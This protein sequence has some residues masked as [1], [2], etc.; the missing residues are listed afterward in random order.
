MV[1]DWRGDVV[2]GGKKWKGNPNVC[3]PRRGTLILRVTFPSRQQHHCSSRRGDKTPSLP[4][5]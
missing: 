1:F 5:K 2:V 3:A 4:Q